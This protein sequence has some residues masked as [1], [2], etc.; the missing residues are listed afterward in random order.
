VL[1]AFG[2][3]ETTKPEE[4]TTAIAALKDQGRPKSTLKAKVAELEPKAAKVP[5]LETSIA[6]LKA[7]RPI[8]AKYVP[9]EQVKSLQTQVA[10]L[11]A[12]NQEREVNELVTTALES[13]KLLPD[14][15]KWAREL[16]K[17]S[18][19]DLKAYLDSAAPIAALAG[20]QTRGRKPDRR[21]TA[22]MPIAIAKAARSSWTKEAKAGRT[23][24]SA[25]A[26][27][28]VSAR[29]EPDQPHPTI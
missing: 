11:T 22:R 8:P 29:P 27:A 15:E 28:R 6:A 3:T 9:I 14:M 5:E 25:E 21:A 1:A 10:T 19:A 20:T 17:K 4:A 13:G 7:G 23:L 24:S 16:G 2:L 26:V 12:A 18:V